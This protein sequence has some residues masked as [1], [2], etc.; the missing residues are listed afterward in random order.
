MTTDEAAETCVRE[1]RTSLRHGP[2]CFDLIWFDL[3]HHIQRIIVLVTVSHKPI[4]CN[5]ARSPKEV[6]RSTGH[7]MVTTRYSDHQGSKSRQNPCQIQPTENIGNI[8]SS[9]RC[10]WVRPTISTFCSAAS[11]SESELQATWKTVRCAANPIKSSQVMRHFR[12]CVN[13]V[14]KIKI[15][16]SKIKNKRLIS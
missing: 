1:N 3:I 8:S 11:I 16:K 15:G 12:A 7:I 2:D 13:D 6:R 10:L 5:P 4:K 14:R 9:R